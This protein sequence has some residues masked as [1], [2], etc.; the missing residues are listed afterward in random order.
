M[1][2][3]VIVDD[4]D[5]IIEVVAAKLEEAGHEVIA[6]RHGDQAVEKVIDTGADLLILDQML[7]GKSGMHILA[8]LRRHP[9]AIDLPIMMLTSRN[10]KLHIDLADQSGADDYVTKPFQPDE[11]PGRVRALLLGARISHDARTGHT[12][13]DVVAAAETD[14]KG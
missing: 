9:D 10:T 13:S 3:I 14:E 8:E 7:P 11:L 5:L 1:A 12:A 6:V 4:D 2:K